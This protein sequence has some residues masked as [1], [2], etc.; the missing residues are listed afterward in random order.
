LAPG[1]TSY[2]DRLVYQTFDVSE[3]LV[4]G[5]NT[6]EVGV[7]EGWYCGKLGWH[8]GRRNIY[9]DSI[10]LIAMLAPRDGSGEERILGTDESWKWAYGQ[11][12]SSELD[13][14]EM[15][16]FN[17]QL[18]EKSTWNEVKCQ[19]ITDNLVAPDGPPVRKTQDFVSMKILRRPLGKMVVD[20][21][22]NMVGRIRVSVD[23]PRGTAINF[24]FVKVLEDGDVVTRTPRDRKAKD[25]LVL[26]GDGRAECEPKFAFHG[27]RY[28]EVENWPG[29][30][31]NGD[32]KGTVVHTDIRETGSFYCSSPLLNKLHEIFRWSMQGNFLS[33]LTDCSQRDERLGSTGAINAFEDTANYPY[34]TAGMLSS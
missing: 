27:F 23:G 18:S 2:G 24:Q 31:E 21:G 28:V 7:A 15:Y 29:K 22:Q 10:R 5:S 11:V 9:G 4:V 6:I 13:D 33:I 19:R 20:L 8:G 30:L 12:V 32:V 3:H 34:D 1:W 16:D 17:A 26:P 25:T 14:G